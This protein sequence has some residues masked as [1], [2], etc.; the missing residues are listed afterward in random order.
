MR[1]S[2]LLL[3]LPLVLSLLFE[4]LLAIASAIGRAG[5]LGDVATIA[6]TLRVIIAILSWF[7][8]IALI[9]HRGKVL[10]R[11]WLV[12]PALLLPGIGFLI[13]IALGTALPSRELVERE[14]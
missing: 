14:T 9:H 6:L 4:L 13:S 1:A 11:R 7:L 12:V 8:L 3:L 10:G 5:A 2:L